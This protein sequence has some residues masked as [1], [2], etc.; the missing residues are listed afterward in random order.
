MLRFS[1]K[2]IV[3]SADKGHQPGLE[4]RVRKLAK[5]KVQWELGSRRCKKVMGPSE[6]QMKYSFK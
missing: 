4:L 2:S 5:G 1:S 6:F 3:E